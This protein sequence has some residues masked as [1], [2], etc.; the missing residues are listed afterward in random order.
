MNGIKFTYYLDC[1]HNDAESG[2]FYVPTYIDNGNLIS[3]EHF[4]QAD[5]K[6]TTNKSSLGANG[7]KKQ[8]V[9]ALYFK[10]FKFL[11]LCMICKM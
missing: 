9:C 6:N 11:Y 2:A 8:K 7:C 3:S 10:S 5:Y 1:G 4:S